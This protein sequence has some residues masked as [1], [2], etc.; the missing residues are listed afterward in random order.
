MTVLPDNK[1]AYAVVQT[2]LAGNVGPI[3]TP[4]TVTIDTQPPT[5]PTLNLVSADDTGS[6]GD[7]ITSV[8]PAPL[9]RRAPSPTPLVAIYWNARL[10]HHLHRRPTPS[11]GR[12]SSRPDLQDLFDGTYTIQARATDAAG[13][14]ALSLATIHLTIDTVPPAVPTFATLVD[15]RRHRPGRRR[16]HRHRRSTTVATTEPTRSR[17]ADNLAGAGGRFRRTQTGFSLV[18]LLSNT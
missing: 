7:G 15:G 9:Q 10:R 3:G 4:Q 17:A 8:Q 16:N 13:N 2:D 5:S 11:P 6:K 1:Y 14:S 18:L 12:S